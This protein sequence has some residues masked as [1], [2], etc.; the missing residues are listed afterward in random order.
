MRA[1]DTTHSTAVRRAL[2]APVEDT[3]GDLGAMP[4]YRVLEHAA[5]LP[6]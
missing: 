3:I 2:D 5:G 6:R 4:G 1:S